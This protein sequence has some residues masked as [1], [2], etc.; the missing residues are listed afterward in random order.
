MKMHIIVPALISLALLAANP[1]GASS[2]TVNAPQ[3]T[4]AEST[5]GTVFAVLKT[6]YDCRVNA[7]RWARLRC[8]IIHGQPTPY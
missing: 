3:A 7:N 5:E 2:S 6:G 1:A 4:S 8:D